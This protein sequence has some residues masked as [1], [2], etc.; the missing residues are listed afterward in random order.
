MQFN[1]KTYSKGHNQPNEVYSLK[2]YINGT[3]WISRWSP[4]D[5]MPLALAEMPLTQP[6]PKSF[7]PFS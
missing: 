1:I 7:H 6:K 3:T 2:P 5:M 4:N